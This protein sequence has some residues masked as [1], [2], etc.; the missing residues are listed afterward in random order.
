MMV[1]KLGNDDDDQQVEGGEWKLWMLPEEGF[2]FFWRQPT[3]L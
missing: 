2:E 1:I 3:C